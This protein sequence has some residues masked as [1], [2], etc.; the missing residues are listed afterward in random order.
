[1]RRIAMLLAVAGIA[2]GASL[3]AAE[4]DNGKP[5]SAK[6]SSGQPFQIQLRQ[7]SPGQFQ[8]DAAGPETGEKAKSPRIVVAK[9]GEQ[10]QGVFVIDE[11]ENEAAPGPY[12]IGLEVEP[13]SNALRQKLAGSVKL[14]EGTGL[15]I[16]EVMPDSPAA[17]AGLKPGDV[18][19]YAGGK[20]LK[21]RAELSAAIQ[22]VKEGSLNIGL[23][24]DGKT[25][26]LAV[27]PAR[28]EALVYNSAPGSNPRQKGETKAQEAQ[29]VE[30]LQRAVK[31]LEA[32]TK[33]QQ[34]GDSSGRSAAVDSLLQA[35]KQLQQQAHELSERLEALGAKSDSDQGRQ[36]LNQ[37]HA[38]QEQMEAVNRQMVALESS[39]ASSGRESSE[40]EQ[41]ARQ[42]KA[43][44]HAAAE[45]AEVGRTEDA[46]NLM[47]QAH[48]L[49]E[50]IEAATP[51]RPALAVLQL[52]PYQ[53]P[54]S[55]VPGAALPGQPQSGDARQRMGQ[56]ATAIQLLAQAG[57]TDDAQRVKQK[58]ESMA[59][60]LET[61]RNSA[62]PQNP[63][64]QSDA[65]S[66]AEL[67]SEIQQLRREVAELRE[68]VRKSQD[69]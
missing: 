4:P 1:M 35:R 69:K 59:R 12:W 27:K 16:E 49:S 10:P 32:Q 14:P 21:E 7:I 40:R 31:Y 64:P 47:R 57:L 18:L 25:M 8:I 5:G 38:V 60:E 63:S 26:K 51:R 56:I 67:R 66:V 23:V 61:A 37:L 55:W 39:R 45:L 11:G 15:V 20:P 24:R 36:L 50:Q 42:M 17:K 6:P 48:E 29:T 41:L 13:P 3:R 9:P 33:S 54:G 2:T 28:R 34:S 62:S 65:S 30:T 53:N 43:L 68:L 44:E 22:A 52:N 58:L 46:R 19:L